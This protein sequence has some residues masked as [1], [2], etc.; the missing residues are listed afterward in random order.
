MFPTFAPGEQ[1]ADPKRF[2]DFNDLAVNS[3]LGREGLER[4][5]KAAVENPR[6]Q[7]LAGPRLSVDEETQQK[8]RSG[9]VIGDDQPAQRRSA[10]I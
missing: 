7:A 1:A 6:A 5:V 8:R 2:T 10:R 9:P 3:S 4:Q